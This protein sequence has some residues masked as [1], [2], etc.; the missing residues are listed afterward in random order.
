MIIKLSSVVEIRDPLPMAY[1]AKG[2]D[3]AT[4]ASTSMICV[5]PLPN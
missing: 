3:A 1:S 5:N 4:F 2:H